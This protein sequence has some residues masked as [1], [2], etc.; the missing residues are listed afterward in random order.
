MRVLEEAIVPLT[1]HTLYPHSRPHLAVFICL[2]KPNGPRK[3]MS[4]E[5]EVITVKYMLGTRESGFKPSFGHP[6]S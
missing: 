4:E 2:Y 6:R 1:D 3:Q 5:A